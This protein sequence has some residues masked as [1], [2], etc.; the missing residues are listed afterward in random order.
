MTVMDKTSTDK[1]LDEFRT[2]VK[3]RFG[4]V[5]HRFEQVDKR[6]EQVDKRFDR[7]EDQIEGLRGELSSQA[8]ETKRGFEAINGRFDSLYRAIIGAGVVIAVAVIG[9]PHI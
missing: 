3:E 2:D 7:V 1:R 5:D 8:V 9:A 4:L 6:F